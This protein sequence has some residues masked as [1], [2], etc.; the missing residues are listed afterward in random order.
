MI[1]RG[2]HLWI[3]TQFL[4]TSK[5]FQEP[6]VSTEIEQKAFIRLPRDICCSLSRNF[7]FSTEIRRGITFHQGIF[8]EPTL[9]TEIEQEAFIKLPIA[10]SLHFIKEF[11][12]NPLF[13]QR[14]ME[15]S[16]STKAF[17][18]ARSFHRG[19]TGCIHP[20]SHRQL[21][22]FNKESSENLHFPQ[23]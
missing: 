12:N 1:Q 8:W 11:S 14:W 9:Y 21:L 2:T 10:I 5:P 18:W 3:S 13:P 22:K 6:A 16:L 19:K 15:V 7:L 23:R 17:L 4:F 20:I